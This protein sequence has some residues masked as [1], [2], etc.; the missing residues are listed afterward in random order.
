[1]VGHDLASGGRQ[2][3]H[4]MGWHITYGPVQ[5]RRLTGKKNWAYVTGGQV[6]ST[7]SVL[8]R[9]VFAGSYDGNLYALQT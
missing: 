2:C 1:V 9:T 5:V 4:R 7:V 8:G 6:V 3:V